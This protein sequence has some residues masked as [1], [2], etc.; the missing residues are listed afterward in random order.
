MRLAICR[1]NGQSGHGAGRALLEF[2]YR[3]ETGRAL[4]ELRVTD[5]GKPYFP[6]STFFF[7]I[8]HTRRH[9]VC[10]LAHCPVGV[11]AEELGRSFRDSFVKRVL[12]PAERKQYAEAADPGRAMLTFWVLK[13]A[14]VKLTGEGLQGFPNHTDFS[15]SDPR[16]R[17]WD[18]CLIALMAQDS[19][20]G[21]I[22]YAL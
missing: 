7:S 20:E 2:L 9:A 12:S 22:F 14:A 4:P 11:D 17:E 21:E 16:V 19:Q 13:E 6:D 1:L 15:L 18:G 8:S 10:A 3:E 5:R